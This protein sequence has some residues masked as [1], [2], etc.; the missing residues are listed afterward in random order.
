MLTTHAS[1]EELVKALSITPHNTRVNVAIGSLE[2]TVKVTEDLFSYVVWPVFS[3]PFDL[4][5]S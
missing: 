2:N 5:I 4:D 3:C 1:T